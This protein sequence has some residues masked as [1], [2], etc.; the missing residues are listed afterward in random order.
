MLLDITNKELEVDPEYEYYCFQNCFRIVLEYLNVKDPLYFLNCGL[1]WKFEENSKFDYNYH[2]CTADNSIDFLPEF[3]NLIMRYDL[4]KN[5]LSEI[6]E[7]NKLALES[8]IP[9]VLAV[10]IFYLPFTPYFQ[11][12][13]S[14]HS[15]IL[16]GYSDNG[17]DAYVIDWY[18]LWKYKG[19]VSSS[20]LKTSRLSTNDDDGI[21]GGINPN[22]ESI[23][24]NKSGWNYDKKDLVIIQFRNYI[25]NYYCVKTRTNTEYGIHA[26]NRLFN[27]VKKYIMDNHDDIKEFMIDLHKQ[28]YFV[29]TRKR[30]FKYYLNNLKNDFR[31][32][33][34]DIIIT[35]LDY[36]YQLWND[37]LNIILKASIRANSKNCKK[38]ILKLEE[39]VLAEKDLSVYVYE[40]YQEFT[41]EKGED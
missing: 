20:I 40:F 18:P 33:K 39:A 31:D 41:F 6:E 28:L 26:L 38:V 4:T 37:L 15:I 17:E 30:L 29:H 12:T 22:A 11:K 23:V 8:G 25:N 14:H 32:L 24:L 16:C 27:F 2:F 1:V 21:L 3:Q 36:T 7:N 10:D 13:H 34:I 9:V 35:Q 5:S 19:A